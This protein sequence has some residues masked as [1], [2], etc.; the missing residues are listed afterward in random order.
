MGYKTDYEM[1]SMDFEEYLWAVGYDDTIISE[2]FMHMTKQIPFNDLDMHVY[3]HHFTDFCILGGMPAVVSAYMKTNTFSEPHEI[4]E[5]LLLDYE[6]DARKYATGL[7]QTRIISVMR[8]VPAQLAKEN[9]KFQYAKIQKGGR[10][11]DYFGC[12]EWLEDAGILNICYCLNFPELPLKGNYDTSKFKLYFCD[13]GLLTVSLDEEAQRN[14]RVNKALGV[15]KGALYENFAA[16]ALHKQGLGL[17]YYKK[18]DSSLEEDFFVRDDTHLI[19]VEV[20]STNN[21]SKSLRTLIQSNRYPDIAYGIKLV[22]G[23]IGYNDGI[24]TFPYFCTF[25]LKRYLH[26]SVQ[27]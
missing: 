15:Y 14:L 13:T 23:N 8:S 2:I 19:P 21:T 17:Y 1:Y 7:D 9:K 10:A 3:M 16:D 11:K 20:K 22:N 18:D 12:I 27:I 24:Y 5:Q 4:Q 6:E 26:E 25:L